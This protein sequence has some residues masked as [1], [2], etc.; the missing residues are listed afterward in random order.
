MQKVRVGIGGR[1]VATVVSGEK[2]DFGFVIPYLK[3]GRC[4]NLKWVGKLGSM[5]QL[6]IGC[7]G[8][9]SGGHQGGCVFMVL[10]PSSVPSIH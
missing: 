4:P 1:W 9:G 6:D 8:L 5:M 2:I 7:D 10:G 3:D